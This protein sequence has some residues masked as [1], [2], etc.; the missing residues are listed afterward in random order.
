VCFVTVSCV[1][2]VIVWNVCCVTVSC[3]DICS[4]CCVTVSCVSRVRSADEAKR[5]HSAYSASDEGRS[6]N[7]VSN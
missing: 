2:G 6:L 7:S 5:R 4:L 3:G 1:S